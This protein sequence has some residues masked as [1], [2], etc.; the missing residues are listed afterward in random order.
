MAYHTYEFLKKRK[1]ETKWR[2]AYLKAKWMRIISFLF[3]V[4]LI[5]WGIFIY[6]YVE[7]NNI[8]IT[9]YIQTLINKLTDL[10]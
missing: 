4:A 10:F 8:D 6:K 2:D 1:N 9:A 5:I 7:Q 3:I